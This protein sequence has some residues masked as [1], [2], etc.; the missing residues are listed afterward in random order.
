MGRATVWWLAAIGFA[1]A[2]GIGGVMAFVPLYAHEALGYSAFVAGLL[3]AVLGIAG[4][5][6]R[7]VWGAAASRFWHATIPLTLIAVLALVST[8]AIRA[9]GEAPVLIWFAVVGAGFSMVAWHA[10][11]W[12]VLID[13]VDRSEVGHA[14]GLVQFGNS[15]GF[16][17][18]PPVV[19]LVVDASGSYGWAWTLVA[20]LFLAVLVS[21]I[22]WRRTS[23]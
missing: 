4:V 7:V 15:A 11:A 20:G 19:G 21:T 17:V 8:L 12:L 22:V 23:T 3:G 13:A 9:A 6:G 14:T 10:V 2:M 16:A 1:V 18:G 5:A